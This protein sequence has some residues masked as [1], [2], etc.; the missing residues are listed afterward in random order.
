[1]RKKNIFVII[2]CITLFILVVSLI[3][4]K[5]T[6]SNVEYKYV[7]EQ[8]KEVNLQKKEVQKLVVRTA[9]A[10]YKNRSYI[11]YRDGDVSSNYSYSDLTVTPED[12]NINNMVYMNEGSFIFSV[13]MNALG[14]DLSLGL[15]NTVDYKNG[16][17]FDVDD[18]LSI[19]A[20]KDS[21]LVFESDEFSKNDQAV[22]LEKYFDNLEPGDIVV[23]TVNDA[24][25]VGLYMGTSI[26]GVDNCMYMYKNDDKS[27]MYLYDV[28]G[29][30]FPN[31]K[32]I[33]EEAYYA[34]IRPINDLSFNSIDQVVMDV[35]V[36]SLARLDDVYVKR[37]IDVLHDN[38]YRGEMIN[39]IIEVVND[40]DQEVLVKNVSDVISDYLT[41]VSSK[42]GIYDKTNKSIVW[43]NIKIS[44]G[45][46]QRF[47]YLV[48]VN[49][50]NEIGLVDSDNSV[51][52]KEIVANKA[53]VLINDEY[54]TLNTISKRIL[55]K[56]IDEQTSEFSKVVND[57]DK[58]KW[59]LSYGESDKDYLTLM[60]SVTDDKKIILNDMS[61]Y[62]FLY[63]NA[64]GIDIGIFNGDNIKN[65]LFVLDSDNNYLRNINDEEN[66]KK[67]RQMVVGNLY[68]G[69]K[70]KDNQKNK[71]FS[72]IIDGKY[73]YNNLIS[74]DIVIYWDEDGINNSYL[75]V[76]NVVNEEKKPLLV[77]FNSDGIVFEN[78]VDEV[79]N[80]KVVNS[81]L[82][83]VLRPSTN[84][85]IRLDDILIDPINL[86]VGNEK[87]I[88]F[89][90]K[91]VNATIS[92]IEYSVSD[93]FEINKDKHLIKG[94]SS[95]ASV[96]TITF[97][98]DLEEKVNVSVFKD[99]DIQV[100]TNYQNDGN[101]MYVGAE[102]DVSIIL[103]N[104]ALNNNGY[105]KK[106]YDE[107]HVEIT[108]KIIDKAFLEISLD[109][110]LVKKY[111]IVIF[112]LV[113]EKH[114]EL[115][116]LEKII[117]Y[118]DVNTSVD[119]FI[120]IFSF[121]KE[122]IKLSVTDVNGNLKNNED[123]LA[124][125]DYLVL[126]ITDNIRDEYQVAVLGDVSGNGI[127][128]GNDIVLTRR[129]IVG[130]INPQTSLVY[131]LSGVYVYAMDYSMNGIVNGNDVSLMRRKLVS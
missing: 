131:E 77:K 122:G 32:F 115:E 103:D 124:T 104:I 1:M 87:E 107:E 96:L 119:E 21:R 24:T 88:E 100:V 51:Y 83:V 52:G 3:M 22:F 98:K 99:T 105:T 82:Y 92:S 48:E 19:I 34:I 42:D 29:Y 64:L 84:F 56:Y 20:K 93:N 46:S 36:N 45:E 31:N 80:N 37:Y 90:K 101:I 76:E 111:D 79:I 68:G 120:K 71:M 26:D 47:S 55:N 130:W 72:T 8:T 67:I 114:E 81:S 16:E 63:Y 125:G 9:K 14:I 106:I 86:L 11:H 62:S 127:F 97:N 75:Y 89:I 121:N 61:F 126:N 74:G 94:I 39:Y 27:G 118:V 60:S 66:V 108:D 123:K 129:H 13:Y 18:I 23:Y 35:P 15:D 50:K 73:T 54:L 4:Y 70:L 109:G 69:N 5:G 95:G 102:R 12:I 65:S 91:P 116:V 38:V 43:S 113:S 85:D 25:H 128:N 17:G 41:F 7:F 112:S 28:L 117:K 44:A 30:L 58:I 10:F 59:S 6:F 49:G 78:D 110:E 57:I 2:S 40:S 53:K 33:N